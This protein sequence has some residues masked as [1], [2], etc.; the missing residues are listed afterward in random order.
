VAKEEIVEFEGV[1]NEV[2]PNTIFRVTLDNGH[3]VTAYASGKIR[4]HRIRILAGDKV[5]LE[6]SPYDMTKGRISFRHKDERATPVRANKPTFY[7]R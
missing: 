1:V 5:T 4:K 2:L 6:M 3:E 7:R